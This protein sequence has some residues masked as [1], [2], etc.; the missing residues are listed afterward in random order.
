MTFHRPLLSRRDAIAR[1]VVHGA[2]LLASISL[3][4]ALAGAQG[5]G[6]RPYMGTFTWSTA[7]PANYTKDF[8]NAFS[9]LGF[10]FEGDRFFSPSVSAGMVL[11]WQEIYDQR[12]FETYNFPQGAATAATYRHLMAWPIL[13]R[14]KY[15]TG[16]SH[17][18]RTVHPFVGGGLGTYYIR[19][20][21]DFGIY[22]AEESN[23]HFGVAPEAGIAFGRT[24][25]A[26]WTLATRYNYPFKAGSY[27]PNGS[28]ASWPFWT[29]SIGIGVAP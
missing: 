1:R 7:Q 14:A 29:F 16:G 25:G 23:W 9:W 26:V 17:Q 19:Q 11:G 21:L 18:G 15:W 22:T 8:I 10:Y 5:L 28:S 6:D 3:M 24:R 2:A 20:T 27:L 4:P 12:P 13:L